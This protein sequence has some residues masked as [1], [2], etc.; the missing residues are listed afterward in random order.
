MSEVTT[1]IPHQFATLLRPPALCVG[2]DLAEFERLR[3]VLVDDIKPVTAI[4]YLLT[5][6]I[7]VAEWELLRLH[8][9]KAGMLNAHMLAALN[10]HGRRW[11]HGLHQNDPLPALLRLMRESAAGDP[12]AR[13]KLE[14]GLKKYQLTLQDLATAAF[15]QTIE[16][17]IQ[18]DRL[19]NAAFHRREAAY[20]EIERRRN[21]RNQS[22]I[23]APKRITGPIIN[24]EMAPGEQRSHAASD[25]TTS[26]MPIGDAGR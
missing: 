25:R 23:D 12:E 21:G 11:S 3:D 10:D 9:F 6:D 20:R 4:E 8:G 15:E 17:Q 26:V 7:I 13:K 24:G 14:R 22:V 18:T 19:I 5:H 2:E 16:A 1:I